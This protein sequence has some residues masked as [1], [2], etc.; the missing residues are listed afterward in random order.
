[1]G[2]RD[3]RDFVDHARDDHE[4]IN[5]LEEENSRLIRERDPRYKERL[6]EA[7]VA[8][9]KKRNDE[10]AN[11]LCK[12]GRASLNKLEVPEDVQRWWKTHSTFDERRGEPWHICTN[13]H[14]GHVMHSQPPAPGSIL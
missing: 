10:L 14:I 7:E 2:C 4:R 8:E 1:M 13:R 6:H 12:A 3:G 9:L 5:Q 11:L